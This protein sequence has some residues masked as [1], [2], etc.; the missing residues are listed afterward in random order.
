MALISDELDKEA[1]INYQGAGA[2]R[3]WRGI[4][5]KSM[6]HYQQSIDFTTLPIDRLLIL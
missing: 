3:I 1:I 6:T 2:T 4:A 5:C